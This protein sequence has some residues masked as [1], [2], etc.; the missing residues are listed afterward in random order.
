MKAQTASLTLYHFEPG[1]HR[2]VCI[3]HDQDHKPEV[4]GTVPGIFVSQRWVATPDLMAA[5]PPSSLEHNGGEYVNMYWTATTPQ[6][7]Q[8]DFA[9]LGR[10]LDLVG[11]MEPMK[12][13]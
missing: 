5:R 1:H 4:V 11:R 3:W 8:A 13:I 12:Y 6:E 10:R 9:A 7:L 2:E